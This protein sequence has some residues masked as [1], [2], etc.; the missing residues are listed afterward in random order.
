MK[1]GYARVSTD[2]QE[3]NLQTDALR[4]ANCDV[5]LEEKASGGSM[6]RPILLKMLKDLKR[7]DVIV[8][9]KLDRIAPSMRDLL[10]I[11][12]RIDEAGAEIKSI[13]EMLDTSNA[14]GRML[15]QILGVFGEFEREVIKERTKAGM[16]AATERGVVLGRKSDIEAHHVEILRLW[17]TGL[18]TKMSLAKRFGAHI[19]SIKRLIVRHGA[20]QK[21]PM[22]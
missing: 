17:A 20:S 14:I 12:A 19:S 16:K 21:R 5:I 13:T 9:Y 1:I 8:I 7:G 11:A 2:E 6:S 3:T 4:K 15:F 10:A 18:I 22:Q